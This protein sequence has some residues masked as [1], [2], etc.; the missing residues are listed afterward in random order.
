MDALHLS[1]H[2]VVYEFP[3]K[4]LLL[5]SKDKQRVVYGEVMREVSEEEFFKSRGGGFKK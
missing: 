4:I 3:Y 2:E 1:Y 5:M